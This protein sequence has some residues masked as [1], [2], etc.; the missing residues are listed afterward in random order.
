MI[1]IIGPAQ[2]PLEKWQDAIQQILSAPAPVDPKLVMRMADA[3]KEKGAEKEAEAVAR[4]AVTVK[5]LD[6]QLATMRQVWGCAM[7]EMPELRIW[8]T[9]VQ[10]TMALE[11]IPRKYHDNLTA[12]RA[13]VVLLE[14]ALRV[15][16]KVIRTWHDM[17]LKA[18]DKDKAWGIY[19]TQS[20]E[21]RV[22]N[23]A[24]NG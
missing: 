7:M 11:G 12:A 22:I 18:E 4:I 8:Y 10:D 20:N 23:N 9:N 1:P 14:G 2:S 19:S 15:A 6:D 3:M 24:L 5:S 13:R 21:M 16:A 17:K